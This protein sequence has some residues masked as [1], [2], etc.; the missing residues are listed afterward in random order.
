V[1]PSLENSQRDPSPWRIWVRSFAA[2]C[3][4][5]LAIYAVLLLLSSWLSGTAASHS[6]RSL[7]RFVLDLA[8]SRGPNNSTTAR[9]DRSLPIVVDVSPFHTD[10]SQPVD[11]ARLDE[12]VEALLALNVGAVGIDI[13]FSPD[14]QGNFIT[15]KDPQL[16]LK[17]MTFRVVRVGVYRREA[18]RPETLL[19]RPEFREL[20]AGMMLPAEDSRYAYYF[21]SSG[22]SGSAGDYLLEM[23]AALYLVRH[24]RHRLVRADQRGLSSSS[25]AESISVG[26]YVVDYSDIDR[27]PRIPYKE[28]GDLERWRNLLDQR[29]VLIADLGDSSDLRCIASRRD[30]VNGALIHASAFVTLD[31]GLLWE[32]APR[33]ALQIDLGALLLVLVC[34]YGIRLMMSSVVAI[35]ALD[36]Q[37]FEILHACILSSLIL[38]AGTLFVHLSRLFWP[39]F[40]WLAAGCFLYPYVAE[41]LRALFRLSTALVAG[42]DTKQV[43]TNE[44]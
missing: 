40:I 8:L 31:R 12:L 44:G 11:R 23:P 35:R 14:D 16:F 5:L 22:D 38:L 19:G 39:D 20:A 34:M 24:P 27:I 17:W 30:P 33:T 3:W 42:V 10:K 26:S 25:E 28:K 1:K 15:T 6:V 29:V 43:N 18:H 36:A 13:D 21:S 9:S 2:D 37:T 41:V 32:I 7:E 4:R